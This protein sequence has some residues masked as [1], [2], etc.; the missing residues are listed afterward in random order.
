[1]T[2]VATSGSASHD[3]YEPIK[4]LAMVRLKPPANPDKPITSFSITDILN[5]Q[6]FGSQPTRERK[7]KLSCPRYAL[8]DLIRPWSASP[9]SIPQ[10]TDSPDDPDSSPPP[11]IVNTDKHYYMLPSPRDFHSDHLTDTDEDEIEVDVTDDDDVTTPVLQTS[12]TKVSP[13]DALLNMTKST[14]DA[15]SKENTE[16]KITGELLCSISGLRP[17]GSESGPCSPSPLKISKAK[18]VCNDKFRA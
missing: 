17:G 18:N 9:P 13:L 12:H 1:M 5:D 11:V 15:K 10:R 8:T 3:R 6:R 2:T 7:R 16:G 14:F 4:R